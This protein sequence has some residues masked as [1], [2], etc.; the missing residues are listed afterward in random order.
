MHPPS[1]AACPSPCGRAGVVVG[2]SY[3]SLRR[4]QAIRSVIRIIAT[5]LLALDACSLVILLQVQTKFFLAVNVFFLVD[6]KLAFSDMADHG[7]LHRRTHGL[8]S[9][10]HDDVTHRD[11]LENGHEGWRLTAVSTHHDTWPRRRILV[12][13][14]LRSRRFHHSR[15]SGCQ[16]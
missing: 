10:L 12:V 6:L 15:R 3:S 14:S 5:A 9:R 1:W 4:P 13:R 11:G 2:A 16:T 8:R 7:I